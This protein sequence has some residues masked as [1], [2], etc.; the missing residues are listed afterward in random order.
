MSYPAQRGTLMED[1]ADPLI[2]ENLIF[3]ALRLG[4]R[5]IRRKVRDDARRKIRSADTLRAV[6]EILRLGLTAGQHGQHQPPST[7]QK[8]S[9]GE[10]YLPEG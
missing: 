1:C 9:C 4:L 2:E 7:P 5:C 6:A 3:D 10:I 8:L